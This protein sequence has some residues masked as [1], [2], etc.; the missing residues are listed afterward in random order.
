MAK[1]YRRGPEFRHMPGPSLLKC[2]S[3]DLEWY[4]GFM[5]SPYQDLAWE[6]PPMNTLSTQVFTSSSDEWLSS[7]VHEPYQLSMGKTSFWSYK[8]CKHIESCRPAAFCN[9]PQFC[10]VC[11]LQKRFISKYTPS[12][13]PMPS[14]SPPAKYHF[15]LPAFLGTHPSRREGSCAQHLKQHCKLL[16]LFS[17]FN[18]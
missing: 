1:P 14:H 7:Y 3:M 13:L 18:T 5:V 15:F 12:S 4:L 6:R 10:S 11:L 17:L 16:M 8:H 2:C 9:C